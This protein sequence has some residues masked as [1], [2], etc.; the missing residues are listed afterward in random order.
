MSMMI[1][2]I[3]INK[4]T[5]KQSANQSFCMRFFLYGIWFLFKENCE[6]LGDALRGYYVT[7]GTSLFIV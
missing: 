3:K 4:W 2:S 1:V 7:I 5:K 6:Y